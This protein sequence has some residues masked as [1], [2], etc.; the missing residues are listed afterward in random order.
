MKIESV[1]RWTAMDQFR[2]GQAYQKVTV[3]AVTLLFIEHDMTTG[4]ANVLKCGRFGFDSLGQDV[5]N[6]ANQEANAGVDRRQ[7]LVGRLL[8]ID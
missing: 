1:D 6:N 8:R 7:R 3:P 4:V 2:R 5:S